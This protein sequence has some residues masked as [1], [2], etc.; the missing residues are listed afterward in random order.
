[1]SDYAFE[2][3]KWTVATVSWY[4]VGGAGNWRSEIAKAFAAW[5]AQVDLDFVEAASA[6]TADIVLNFGPIDGALN[7][8]G[9]TAYSY[10]IWPPAY[11]L[12]HATIAFDS[13]ESWTW[14]A[15]ENSYVLGRGATFRE[16][17]L[18]EIGHAIGL[19]HATNGDVLMYPWIDGSATGL[20]G[21][22]I[23]AARQLYGAEQTPA[24][25]ILIGTAGVDVLTGGS[26]ADYIV[27]GAGADLLDGGGGAGDYLSYFGEG[28]TQGV[29]VSLSA[30]YAKDSFGDWDVVSSFEYISGS[31]NAYPGVAGLSDILAGDAGS[32]MV[33]GFGGRDY[34]SAGFGSDYLYG[35]GGSDIFA[36]G[37]DVR[38]GDY[39]LIGDL[40]TGGEVDY[41]QLAAAYRSAVSFGD[42]G[43]Y[44]YAYVNMG[45]AGGYTV[46]A[47]GVIGAQLQA[48]TYFA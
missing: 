48:Q 9:R 3:V 37:G 36:L 35:G 19:A 32:N 23:Y 12:A 21:W 16:L 44:A 41:L 10:W 22:D 26:G 8:I 1:M 4:W 17:A 14:S 46:L 18:H 31:D 6:A 25:N 33:F 5:D 20:T 27:G 29:Y 39:D 38:A 24:P 34:I 15:A 2:G 7:S 30:G 28:G 11:P 47:S 13:A 43:G 42:Y 40:N 45:A